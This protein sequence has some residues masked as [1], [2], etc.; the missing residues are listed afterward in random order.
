MSIVPED[1]QESPENRPMMTVY[2][3]EV[4]DNKAPISETKM[5]AKKLKDE[6]KKINPDYVTILQ[7]MNDNHLDITSDR[8]SKFFM[9]AFGLTDRAAFLRLQKAFL[10][11]LKRSFQHLDSADYS[12]AHEIMKY[13]RIRKIVAAAEALYGK[14]LLRLSR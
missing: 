6:L 2:D 10:T 12:E 11:D 5:M 3:S 14:L 8:D 1:R 4:A 13:A 9:K 7:L